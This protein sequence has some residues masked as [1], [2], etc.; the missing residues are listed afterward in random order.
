MVETRKQARRTETEMADFIKVETD[1]YF[2]SEAFQ[3]SLKVFIGNAVTAACQGL[4]EKIVA[5]LKQEIA[6]LRKEIVEAKRKGN[7]NE[8]YS[9]R[10]NVRIYGFP[11]EKDEDCTAKV[12]DFFYTEM[13]LTFPS[14]EI[15][16]AHRVGRRNESSNKGRPVIVK[17]KSY[18]SKR[19]VM[20]ARKE[21]LQ[22]KVFYIHEDL[23]FFNRKL[24]QL[25]KDDY[26]DTPVWS[27][28]GRILVK[29][30]GRVKPYVPSADIS[31]WP[32]YPPAVQAE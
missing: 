14:N 15:D 31:G 6:D 26:P 1:K 25:A 11:E 5:P 10:S 12:V 13:G 9:R 27:V 23:T 20:K 22:G 18:N 17:F 30:D 4:M 29:L 8:Q 24:L 19:A 28:D 21:T 7:D 32:L 16:R 2:A 3:E